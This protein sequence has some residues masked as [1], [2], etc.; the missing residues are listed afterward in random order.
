MNHIR[1][2]N[3]RRNT[4]WRSGLQTTASLT[5]LMLGL[6]AAQAQQQPVTPVPSNTPLDE[7]TVTATRR[8]ERVVDTLGSVSVITRQEIRQ[9]QPQRLGT[10]ISQTPG[11]STQENPNDPATAINIRGLQDFG[12]V[13]VTVDGARQNFQRSGHNA[14]G[15]F[16][17]DPVFVRSIDITRGPVA[18]I[19]GSGAIGGVV[20]FETLEPRDILKPGERIAGELGGTYLFGRQFGFNGSG[21]AAVRPFDNLEGLVGASFRKPGN[22]RDGANQLIV[23]TEQELRSGLAKIVITPGDGHQI[24]VGGQLQ[25]YEFTNGGGPNPQ[26][27][28]RRENDVRTSNIFARYTFS[29]PD[30]PFVN[31]NASVYQTTTETDQRRVNGTAAQ[32]G[33]SRFFNIR[34]TGFDVNNT[35]KFDFGGPTLALTYGGDYF[36]DRVRT[37]DLFGNGDEL[38][39]SGRRAVS[40]GFIQAALK[41]GAFDLIGGLRYD[42]YELSSATQSSS[43]QRLSP[44]VTL[45]YTVVPGIQFYGTY[46]EGYR[47]PAITETLVE[48]LHPAPATFRFIP[49]PNLRP[50]VGKTYEAGVNLK[51]DDVITRGDRL[52]GKLSAFTNDV[53]NFIDGV[54]TDPGA[55]CGAPVRGACDDAFFIYRNI[56]SARLTGV[57]GEFLYDA[58]TYFLSA[59][60]SSIRGDDRTANQPLSSVYPDKISLGGGL[61]FFDEKLTIAAKINLVGSQNKVPTGTPTSKAYTLVDLSANY[62]LTPDSR[63]FLTLENIGDVRYQRF[64]DGDRS[65]GF[66]GKLG[67]STRFGT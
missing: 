10:I 31:L 56:A 27:G 20:S 60:G 36:L 30:N 32:I 53:T 49:N 1:N 48:G 2:G 55:P 22:Y 45:G 46:A 62:Q 61:R 47:A 39:P 67:F 17:L 54:F 33:Q 29:R 58:R 24:K 43:G 11:V 59:S 23:D 14:N 4:F 18:N 26:T 42:R 57:E 7:I 9:Q 64:R 15:S 19:Y 21:I 40:G 35:T 63:A 25:K 5:A 13:A 3:W 51:F 37:Q 50:E 52:R 8:P 12:R 65:P 28:T 16:F 44:K 66:V 41:V 6:S 34:T 38:T